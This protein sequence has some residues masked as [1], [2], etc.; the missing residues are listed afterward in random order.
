MET[1]SQNVVTLLVEQQENF[2]EGQVVHDEEVRNLSEIIF[3][4]SFNNFIK[5]LLID[6][7]TQG[8]AK[9]SVLDLCCG[10]GGD[11]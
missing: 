9:L 5:A 7:V 4:K 2:Y 11:I 6:E 3:L 8:V 1:Q 10:K